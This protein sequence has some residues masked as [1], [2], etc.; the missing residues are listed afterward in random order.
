MTVSGIDGLLQF[1]SGSEPRRLEFKTAARQF[2]SDKLMRYCCALSRESDNKKN[3]RPPS[4]GK[5]GR[6][7]HG[8]WSAGRP[9][10]RGHRNAKTTA[11]AWHWYM[12]YPI[13]NAGF[14]AFP[15]DSGYPNG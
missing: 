2:D 14:P 1:L 7:I 3:E 9:A 6:R 8:R 13:G 5:V 12:V 11:T 10:P 4:P 15:I